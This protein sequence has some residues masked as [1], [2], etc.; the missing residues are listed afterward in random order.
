MVDTRQN[1]GRR[2]QQRPRGAITLAEETPDELPALLALAVGVAILAIAI[3][4]PTIDPLDD[5]DDLPVAAAESTGTDGQPDAEPG[6]G[7]E[8]VEVDLAGIRAALAELGFSGLDLS[9]DGGVVTVVGEVPDDGARVEVIDFVATQPGVGS[10]IDQLVVAEP[11]PGE[12]AD[13]TVTAAQ[14]SVVLNGTVPDEPTAQAIYDRAVAIYS[15]DQVDNQLVIDSA[16]VAPTQ[17]T[18]AGAMTDEVLFD[19]VSSGFDDL[20]GVEVSTRSLALEESGELE[21]ALN[22]LVPIQFAS[23]SAIIDPASEATLDEAADVLSANPDAVVE[24]GGHTDSRGSEESNQALSQARADAV[25]DALEERGVTNEL[26][27][28]GFGERRPKIS[29]DDTPEA[30]QE[31]RR[32]E[33]RQL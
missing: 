26:R 29:P 12:S 25:K 27:A 4:W 28:V 30:Q 1:A 8:A 18:I 3:V 22:A 7:A 9:A 21:A 23:G 14:A 13:A 5:H 6:E 16:R 20:D 24:I 31:N 2:E 33:F 15:E 19:Q 10:V 32:I 11:E 17:I